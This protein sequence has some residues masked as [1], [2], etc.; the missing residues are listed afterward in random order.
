MI[1]LKRLQEPSIL[2][3]KKEQ[4]TQKLLADRATKPGARPHSSQYA[5]KE[6]VDALAAMSSHKCFYCE[7]ST[8]GGNHEVDHY[9]EV[10]IDPSRAFVWENLYLAC[11]ECN[12]KLKGIAA[13]DCLDPCDPDVRPGEHLIFDDEQIR[14]RNDSPRGASTIKKYRL[15]REDLDL[16]RSKRLKLFLKTYI[17]IKDC[18]IAEKRLEVSEAEKEI[19]RSFRYASQ[20]FSL[21]FT[22]Y[23]DQIKL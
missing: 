1:P 20:P 18:M 22:V 15:D 17:K 10:A 19:L 2:A 14:P 7:Q 13:S 9:V 16:K 5:H 8:K 4:W 21:M 12:D 11:K 6:I 3:E 23:L